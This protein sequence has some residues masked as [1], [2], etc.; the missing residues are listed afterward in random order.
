M[1]LWHQ[2]SVE[3]FA[4]KKLIMNQETNINSH[5]ISVEGAAGKITISCDNFP[6]PNNP[7]T[8]YLAALS[9]IATLKKMCS[10]IKIGT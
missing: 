2:F 8:S 4:W 10:N 5:H 9:A 6:S 1:P 3:A 7:R